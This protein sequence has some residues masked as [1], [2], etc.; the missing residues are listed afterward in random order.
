MHGPVEMDKTTIP[1][2]AADY[3]MMLQ[4]ALFCKG[5]G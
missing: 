3:A 1:C 5:M 2:S 4:K